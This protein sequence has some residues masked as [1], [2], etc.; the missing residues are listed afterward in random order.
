MLLDCRFGSIIFD[1]A[2]TRPHTIVCDQL[3]API[4]EH[5]LRLD[6]FAHTVFVFGSRRKDHFKILG[7]SRNSFVIH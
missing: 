4:I 6:P 1:M 3:A 2:E 7:G 5:E